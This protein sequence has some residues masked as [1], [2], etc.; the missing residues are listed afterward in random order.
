MVP[1]WQKERVFD[2]AVAGIRNVYGSTS[3][4]GPPVKLILRSGAGGEY[5]HVVA[6]PASAPSERRVTDR[7]NR[8]AAGSDLLE[9]A[10]G[11]E[12]DEPA[13]GRPERIDPLLGTRQRL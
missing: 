13:V 7:L 6:V 4:S 9:F 3:G 1:V 11:E 5:D 10:I 2:A 12:S 8:S